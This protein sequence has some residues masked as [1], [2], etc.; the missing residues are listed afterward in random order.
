MDRG[1]GHPEQLNIPTWRG[2]RVG[3]GR[4]RL[5]PRA[6]D[7]CYE[8]EEV[9]G[10]SR[11]VCDCGNA[12]REKRSQ[13]DHERGGPVLGA[14]ATEA[15]E[16]QGEADADEAAT[17][18]S[19]HRPQTS[20][21][22]ASWPCWVWRRGA[23][24]RAI[25]GVVEAGLS[26]QQIAIR[27]PSPPRSCSTEHGCGRRRVPHDQRSDQPGQQPSGW[28]LRPQESRRS[29]DASVSTAA[30]LQRPPSAGLRRSG[31]NTSAIVPT[32][33][34]YRRSPR[35]ARSPRAPGASHARK[36]SGTAT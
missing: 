27:R 2:W 35:D 21:T 22:R 5:P 3:R 28:R 13:R 19:A 23:I 14:A 36:T 29:D 31:I 6:G 24:T 10:G 9:G 8:P 20:S 26:F 7:R 34:R 11:T 33:S 25:A 1:Q 30:R 12:K 18:P 32:V 16:D 4:D 17:T 15:V